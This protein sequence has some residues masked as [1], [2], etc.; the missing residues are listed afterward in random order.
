MPLV[1]NIQ[2]HKEFGLVDLAKHVNDFYHCRKRPV[3]IVINLTLL[4]R[5]IEVQPR[6][7]SARRSTAAPV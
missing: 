7:S 6:Q 1:G 3:E 5:P 2:Q 4:E